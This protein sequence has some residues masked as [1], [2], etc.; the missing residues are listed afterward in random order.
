MSNTITVQN[1]IISNTTIFNSSIYKLSQ[2]RHEYPSIPIIASFSDTLVSTLYS[3]SG[4]EVSISFTDP[5]LSLDKGLVELYN[6]QSSVS[7]APQI[8][9]INPSDRDGIKIIKKNNY[10]YLIAF[11]ASA[12]ILDGSYAIKI[13]HPLMENDPVYIF[14]KKGDA[15]SRADYDQ[16]FR[17]FYLNLITPTP[18]PTSTPTPTITPTKTVTPTVTKTTTPTLT[19]TITK[20]PTVTRTVTPTVSI[21]SSKRPTPTPSM[22]LCNFSVR[23]VNSFNAPY[24]PTPTPTLTTNIRYNNCSLH[25]I[26]RN[27]IPNNRYSVHLEF[28]KAIGQHSIIPVEDIH[29]I[30]NSSTVENL[31]FIIH[32]PEIAQN[33]IINAHVYDLDA[34]QSKTISYTIGQSLTCEC[35]CPFVDTSATA[36]STTAT[37]IVK[38]PLSANYGHH[39]NWDG[40]IG[41]VT[42]VGTNGPPSYYGTYDQCGNVWE[43]IDDI[44]HKPKYRYLMGGSWASNFFEMDS[45]TNRS[46]ITDI[47]TRTSPEYGFRIASY[48]NP[49]NYDCFTTVGDTCNIDYRGVGTLQY[50]YEIAKY[51]VT[52]SDYCLFLNS[53]AS[54]EFVANILNDQYPFDSFLD[55][56]AIIKSYDSIN[57]FFVYSVKQNM[58][59]KPVTHVSHISAKR[60][61]N[62]LHHNKP[63]MLTL[64][65][66]QIFDILDTG[67]YNLKNINQ[68]RSI[69]AKYFLPNMHEW[70]KAAYYNGKYKLYSKYSM[71]SSAVSFEESNAPPLF[72]IADANGN[73]CYANFDFDTCFSLSYTECPGFSAARVPP[74]WSCCPNQLGAAMT[75]EYCGII[76]PYYIPVTLHQ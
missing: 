70:Y 62:W 5:V 64:P 37:I 32:R 46:K 12:I 58:L 19:K 25:L 29:F 30:A 34:L 35:E 7:L 73:G 22:T 43:W 6:C 61:I 66:T 48:H 42:A 27:L 17:E 13:N 54:N 47:E 72:S 10:D 31:S 57:K 69:D 39:A 41:N 50:S 26:L 15:S 52:N 44:G 60:Y 65:A 21:T 49:N 68:E 4:F 16:C 33:C 11:P 63:F 8:S 53:V 24:T 74:N 71:Y 59:N 14:F 55:R 51:P 45:T 36:V 23:D 28:D 9:S 1:V 3:S 40:F 67:A 56:I 75:Q 38:N 2:Y 76:G 18:T 20:T